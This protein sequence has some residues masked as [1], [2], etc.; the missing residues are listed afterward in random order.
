MAKSM[1]LL[2]MQ[3]NIIH[4]K[5]HQT[6]IQKRYNINMMTIKIEIDHKTKQSRAAAEYAAHKRSVLKR[7]TV[8]QRRC[9]R[10]VP[11][12]STKIGKEGV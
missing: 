8:T 12:R 11:Y 7:G 5:D 3:G 10:L 6:K 4:Q 9:R 2:S 1:V